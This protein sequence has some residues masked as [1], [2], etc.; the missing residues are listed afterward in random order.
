MI[1][2]K[3][4]KKMFKWFAD[5]ENIVFLKNL[6]L[7][8]S[9]HKSKKTHYVKVLKVIIVSNRMFKSHMTNSREESGGEAKHYR[10]QKQIM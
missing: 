1:S 7:R 2:N 4:C 3:S 8:S 5:E 6:H 9:Y 10:A